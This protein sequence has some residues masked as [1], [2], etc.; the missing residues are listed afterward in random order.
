MGH[1]VVLRIVIESLEL[2]LL[3]F[4]QLLDTEC[5]PSASRHGCDVLDRRHRWGRS[6]GRTSTHT[7]HSTSTHASLSCSV[8]GYRI[9]NWLAVDL[10]REMSA[11]IMEMTSSTHN[12]RVDVSSP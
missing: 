7:S 3:S 5:V 6:G 10:K 11:S 8:F 1:S 9:A 12:I 4:F 2:P